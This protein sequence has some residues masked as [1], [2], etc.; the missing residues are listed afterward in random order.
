MEDREERKRQ[1]SYA[2][3]ERARYYQKRPQYALITQVRNALV[4]GNSSEELIAMVRSLGDPNEYVQDH[5]GKIWVPLIYLAMRYDTQQPFVEYLLKRR[6][7]PKRLPDGD[8]AESIITACHSCYLGTLKGRG[9]SLGTVVEASLT[10]LLR[11]GRTDRLRALVAYGFVTEDTIRQFCTNGDVILDVIKAL[12][13]YLLYVYNMKSNVDNKTETTRQTIEE[14]RLVIEWAQQYG[15]LV[16]KEAQAMMLDYYLY[17]LWPPGVN[18]SPSAPVYHP[19][20]PG[21]RAALWRPLLNDQR[22]VRMC[23]V[24]GVVPDP[25]VFRPLMG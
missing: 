5:A 8:G 18:T 22:Y 16:S 12:V 17:E 4:T 14:F 24:V 10:K 19:L 1:A 3:Y 9:V 25:D 7:D 13:S 6:A 21:D 11:T 20:M 23:E 15:A 2:A